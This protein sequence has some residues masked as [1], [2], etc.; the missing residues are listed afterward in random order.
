MITVVT[1][2]SLRSRRA[3]IADAPGSLRRF[4]FPFV[5]SSL[6]RLFFPLIP[7]LSGATEW[8]KSKTVLAKQRHFAAALDKRKTQWRCGLSYA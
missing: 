6:R 2:F 3:G 8:H 5:P 1:G 4:F 7:L